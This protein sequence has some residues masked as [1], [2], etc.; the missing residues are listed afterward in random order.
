MDFPTIIL[1][2]IRNIE[3]IVADAFLELFTDISL[4]LPM[5]DLHLVNF[6]NISRRNISYENYTA[7]Y[8]ASDRNVY[9]W[10]C[11]GP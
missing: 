10:L 5:S 2:M 4:L 8:I 1:C 9:T 6:Q 3:L 11:G 7:Y